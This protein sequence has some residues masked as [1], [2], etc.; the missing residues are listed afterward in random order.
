LTAKRQSEKRRYVA[1]TAM[2]YADAW[3]KFGVNPPVIVGS[4][5]H[6]YYHDLQLN[7]LVNKLK[8]GSG[9]RR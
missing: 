6:K 9:M 5:P 3:C 2:G 8:V 7:Y 4:W 1:W